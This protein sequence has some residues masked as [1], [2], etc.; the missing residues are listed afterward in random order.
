MHFAVSKFTAQLCDENYRQCQSPPQRAKTT[1]PDFNYPQQPEPCTEKQHRSS[2][3][4]RRRFRAFL[5]RPV[6]FCYNDTGTRPQRWQSQIN[7]GSSLIRPRLIVSRSDRIHHVC[8]SANRDYGIPCL[9]LRWRNKSIPLLE[10]NLPTLSSDT[11]MGRNVPEEMQQIM[12]YSINSSPQ[13]D[14][15]PVIKGRTQNHGF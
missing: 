10:V 1:S 4:T 3:L 11:S 8:K 12:L 14:V 7:I 6:P 15:E 13:A 9:I 2:R 5:V